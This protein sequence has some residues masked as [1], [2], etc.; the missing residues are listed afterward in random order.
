MDKK[1][2]WNITKLLL[3]IVVTVAALYLV[4]REVNPG[5]LKEAFIHSDHWFFLLAFISFLVSQII[6]SSRL[7]T[8]FK[9]IGLQISEQYN[10]RLYLLGMFYNIFLPGGIGGDGY[11][12]FFLRKRFSIKGRRLLLALFF[13]RLSGLW[14][15]FL[16]IACLI[17]FIPS[18]GIPNWIPVSTLV[19]GSFIYYLVLRRFFPDYAVKF[20]SKHLKAICVQSF[21]IVAAIMIL[22]AL[23]F[24][25]KFSPYLFIFLGS[26]LAALFPFTVGGLGAREIIIIEGARFFNLDAH[27]AV[28]I[29]LSFY[30]LTALLSL[31]GSYFIFRPQAL[32]EDKLPRDDNTDLDEIEA[33]Y[34][35][36]S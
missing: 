11:K 6:S 23:H 35:E 19:A 16:I 34:K 14:A 8:Y 1:K 7:N 10:F 24:E 33:L 13:D 22:Y 30:V 9:G 17:I 31:G 12:I 5:D 3:K 21:Q 26:S 32:G 4:F 25:G 29:S 28:L 18:I 27:L 2:L 20:I 36:P 15:M